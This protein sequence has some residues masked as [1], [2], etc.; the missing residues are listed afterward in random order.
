MTAYA[1]DDTLGRA[2]LTEPYGYLVKP[3]KSQAL[4]TTIELH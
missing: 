2:K 3:F 1:D 4:K